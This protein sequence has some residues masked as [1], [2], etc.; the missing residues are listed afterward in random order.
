MS[1]KQEFYKVI[2]YLGF[3]E[4]AKY[5]M[6]CIESYVNFLL[7]LTKRRLVWL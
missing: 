1:L 7:D 4:F 3:A 6:D 2:N 5:S